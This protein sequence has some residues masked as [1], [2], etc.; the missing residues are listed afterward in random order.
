MAYFPFFID[1]QDKH[2]LVVGGGAVAFRKVHVLLQF[3]VY[4]TVVSPTICKE[5]KEL[6]KVEGK[7]ILLEREFENADIQ[8]CFFV[9]A[10][11]NN[12]T[13]NEAIEVLCKESNTLVNL[14]DS[15]DKSAFL[16]PAVVKKGDIV[17]GTTTAGK[18]PDIAKWVR[19]SVEAAVPDYMAEL[20]ECLGECRIAIKERIHSESLRKKAFKELLYIG[21]KAEGRIE[22]DMIEQVIRNY[23]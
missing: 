15:C 20:T 5:L 23:E 10:A 1:I 9:I 6:S 13:V 19:M 16:F 12:R 11:T 7:L 8:H 22:K 2:C 14:A 4:V 21:M 18:S 3:G 17:I